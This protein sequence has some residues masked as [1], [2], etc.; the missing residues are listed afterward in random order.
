MPKPELLPDEIREIAKRNALPLRH[1]SFDSD[2]DHIARKVLGLAPGELLWE[3]RGSAGR[4]IWGA[5][6]GGMLAAV[7]LLAAA[8]AHSALLQRPVSASIGEA[9]TTIL[10]GGV[11]IFG[12]ISGVI[13]GSRGRRIN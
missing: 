3:N 10:I 9:Q 8:L 1:E 13:Y 11:L 12:L 7:F 2:A 5:I 4:K 6:A